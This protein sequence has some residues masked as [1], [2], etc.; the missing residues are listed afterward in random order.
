[1][2]V[3]LG[4]LFSDGPR[5]LLHAFD[6]SRGFLLQV[7]GFFPSDA[8]DSEKEWEMEMCSLYSAALCIIRSKTG[9]LLFLFDKSETSPNSKCTQHSESPGRESVQRQNCLFLLKD[10]TCTER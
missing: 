4:L 3:S 5:E 9:I 8:E 6:R 2:D 10:E 7:E 1:M